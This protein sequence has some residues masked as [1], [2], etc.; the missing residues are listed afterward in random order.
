MNWLRSII[1]VVPLYLFLG[2]IITA[3]RPT[4]RSIIT[5]CFQRESQRFNKSLALLICCIISLIAVAPWPIIWITNIRAAA[6]V[7]NLPPNKEQLSL[8]G[9]LKTSAASPPRCE[10]SPQWCFNGAAA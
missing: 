5:K 6:A 9:G 7:E 4:P 1:H 10:N 8:F 3:F 2:F